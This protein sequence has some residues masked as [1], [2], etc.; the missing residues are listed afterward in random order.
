MKT[1]TAFNH[2]QRFIGLIQSIFSSTECF[3]RHH[4]EHIAE[5]KKIVWNDPSWNK[6]P[7][8]VREFVRGYESARWEQ[9]TRYK[10][11]WV[12]PFEGVNYKKWD[13]LPE[14]GKEAYRNGATG[15][16]VHLKNEAKEW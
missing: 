15:K 10:I 2:Q 11:V 5:M 9:F 4:L 14:E 6:C 13:D 3:C 8:H 12:L 16:H 1:T 7:R